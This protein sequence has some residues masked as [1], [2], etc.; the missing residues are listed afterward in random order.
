MAAVE[1][2]DAAATA[3]DSPQAAHAALHQQQQ[4]HLLQRAA[5]A[6]AAP[7]ASSGTL[8]TAPYVVPN[9]G[10]GLLPT[11]SSA[12][13]AAGAAAGGPSS[14]PGPLAAPHP[15]P[16]PPPPPLALQ[17][18]PS[19][20]SQR[21]GGAPLPPLSE[22]QLRGVFTAGGEDF[23]PVWFYID[24]K[25]RL[26]GPFPAEQMVE[27]VREAMLGP[28]TPV[29]GAAPN[30]EVRAGGMGLGG[31]GWSWCSWHAPPQPGRRVRCRM[32]RLHTAPMTMTAEP[33]TLWPV[34]ACVTCSLC[35]MLAAVTP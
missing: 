6:T 2:A 22:Q 31:M 1:A 16:P 28:V 4:Q 3:D 5:S 15:P 26:Q 11:A 34:W 7:G 17:K 18:Q 24:P 33:R 25:D 13:A 29:C 10:D 21:S 27:W 23:A 30:T 12:P 20:G 14:G 32:N 9:L 35:N 8:P 19:L